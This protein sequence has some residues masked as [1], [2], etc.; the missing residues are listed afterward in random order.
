MDWTHELDEYGELYSSSPDDILEELERA[1]NLKTL[2]PRMLSGR[3]Q[4]AFLSIISKLIAPKYILEIGT[5]TGYSAICL[6]KGLQPGGILVTIDPN[7]EI[8][9]LARQYISKANLD[10]VIQII[11]GMAKEIIPQL[12]YQFDLVFIDADKSS[13]LDYYNMIKPKIRNGGI[14]L[15]DNVLWSGKVFQKTRDQKTEKIHEF[16][17]FVAQDPE[18]EVVIL[19]L[20][21]G[22]SVIRKK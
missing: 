5:F 12:E 1:T 2:Q 17:A 18:V 4:G 3:W 20:R 15:A 7:K 8:L 10:Q 11:E 19:P 9:Q 16:N 21:D 14:I 22:I 13:Y 6:S